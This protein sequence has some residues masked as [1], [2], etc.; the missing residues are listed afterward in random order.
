MF[1]YYYDPTYILIIIGAVIC[2]AAQ[3]KVKSTYAAYSKVRNARGFTGRDAAEKILRDSGLYDVQIHHISGEMTDYYDPRSKRVCLSD[4]TYNS[5]SVAA[6]GIAA[7][8]CGHAIQHQQGF[9]FLKFR[10][11]MVPVVNFGSTMCWPL[12]IIGFIFNGKNSWM[13]LTA[14]VLLFSLSVLFQL[15]TL[16]VEFNASSRAL[17]ILRD[18]NMMADKE[19]KGTKKVLQAAA[20]TYVASCAAAVL[21]VI[22][23][24][25]ITGIRGGG[26]RDD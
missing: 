22:R 2:L 19:L 4:S 13:F 8:E 11:S 14:G 18:S 5:T 23:L 17:R 10:N 9:G 21:Q 1:Y 24:I 26:R 20:L 6:L 12:I 3:A 15:V 25:L 16:P 7:H